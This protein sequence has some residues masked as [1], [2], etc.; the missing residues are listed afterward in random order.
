[1]T[2]FNGKFTRDLDNPLRWHI[3]GS[4]QV[5]NSNLV[6]ITEIPPFFTCESYEEHLN[7]LVEK[8]DI[9]DYEDNCSGNI[10]YEVKFHRKT[11]SDLV[12]SQK[13]GKL[14]RMSTTETEN[15]TVIDE[16]GVLQVFA[17][18][19][20]IISHFV[21]VRLGYY[22]LRKQHL[23]Q[24]LERELTMISNR[25][26]FIKDI[27]EGRLAINNRPK[28]AIEGDL[29]DLRYDQVDGSWGYLL[30]MPIH[31]LTSERFSELLQV[32]GEKEAEVNAVRLIQPRDMYVTDLTELQRALKTT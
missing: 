23:I 17:K 16:T 18:A 29:S 22:D 4:Y 1:M 12:S 7:M 3:E 19:E 6:K 27:I 11:L 20:D 24:K 8:G 21:G 26:R 9:I 2:G 25:A 15:L 13:L 10:N 28:A 30:S 32:K 31:S 5:A 14:L